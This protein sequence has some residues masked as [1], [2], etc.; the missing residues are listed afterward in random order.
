M[1]VDNGTWNGFRFLSDVAAVIP[2]LRGELAKEIKAALP[3]RFNEP[4]W[5]TAVI[6]DSRVIASRAVHL[7]RVSFHALF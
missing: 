7:R 5:N 3:C 6:A 1:L 2:S 4:Q